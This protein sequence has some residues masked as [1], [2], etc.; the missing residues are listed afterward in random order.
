MGFPLEVYRG[1]AEIDYFWKEF[2]QV[3]GRVAD[4]GEPSV[5]FD[6]RAELE[7]LTPDDQ[8]GRE[9]VRSTLNAG[10]SNLRR[11]S[12]IICAAWMCRCG[13]ASLDAALAEIEAWRPIDPSPVLL[14]SVRNLLQ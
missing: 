3:E 6:W 1:K 9:L 4:F 2:L 10:Y 8:S 14:S 5:Y 13:Y 12:P 11:G 7:Y